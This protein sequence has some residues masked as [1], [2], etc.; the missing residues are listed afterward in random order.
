MGTYAFCITILLSMKYFKSEWFIMSNLIFLA[1]II[2][3]GLLFIN[4]SNDFN[5]AI[6]LMFYSIGKR[7]TLEFVTFIIFQMMAGLAAAGTLKLIK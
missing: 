5:P 6:T 3:I 7:T 1:I 4:V 2:P